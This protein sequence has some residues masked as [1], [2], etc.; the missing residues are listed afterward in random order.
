MCNVTVISKNLH[1]QI[2]HALK[3]SSN[4]KILSTYWIALLFTMWMPQDRYQ[5]DYYEYFREQ[6]T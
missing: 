3:G 5:S 4:M 2:K 1:F 6:Y